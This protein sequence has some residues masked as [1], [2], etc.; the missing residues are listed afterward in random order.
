M[1]LN[2]L[3]NLTGTGLTIRD[4]VKNLAVTVILAFI[5]YFVYKMTYSGVV[6]S[7]SFNSSLVMTTLVT[8]I[9]MMVIRNN[10]AL[11][12]GMVGALSIVR[13]R[14]AVKEP[15]DISYIFWGIAVGLSAGTGAYG[16]A[17]IGSVAMTVVVFLL[18]IGSND[19]GNSYL[20]IIKG[21]SIDGDA[22]LSK[23][24]SLT[25]RHK[26][27]MQ[28]TD[29]ENIEFIF[30]IRLGKNSESKII[31]TIKEIPGVKV[32]NIVSYTGSVNG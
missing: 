27:K 21:A 20:L 28:N 30:E 7:K 5:I 8:A 15:K 16:I 10:L 1:N 31:E 12:L 4:I 25:K 3:M 23:I 13:F 2:Q 9:V 14:A 26:L 19:S 24:G 6:Y 18:G 17:I 32:A 29:S 11:S 22:I